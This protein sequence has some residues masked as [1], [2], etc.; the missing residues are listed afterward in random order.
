MFRTFRSV[1]TTLLL[2]IGL[3]ASAA[4][5]TALT[6][7]AL[8]TG[9]TESATTIQVASATG[10]DAEDIVF[11]D[12]EALR[13]TGVNGT[14][15]TVQR[16]WAGTAARAHVAGSLAYVAAPGAYIQGAPPSGACTR[17]SNQFLPRILLPAGVIYDCPVGA[18]ANW[19]A[20]NTDLRTARTRAFDLDNGAGTTIDVVLT[21]QA[22]PIYIA[23]C[24]I[25]YEGATAGTVAAGYAQV[26]TT[27]DGEQIVAETNYTNASTVGATTAMVIVNGNVAAN[28]PVL[29]RHTGVA[30]TAAGEAAVE[31]DYVYR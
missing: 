16:G 13:V 25:V 6:T 12:R 1:L 7:T 27:V 23:S 21:R 9:V 14:S 26:G 3:A 22:R 5:Q 2:V 17:T 4:A 20:I 10:F 28:T 19:T 29:V 11:I 18:N 15:I 8:S 24:R 30:S 31:C